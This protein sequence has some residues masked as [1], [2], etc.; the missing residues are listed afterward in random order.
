M[1]RFTKLLVLAV[2]L[3]WAV[4]EASA[5]NNRSRGQKASKSATRAG[6]SAGRR[7]TPPARGNRGVAPTRSN[8]A[9]ARARAN[10]AVARPRAER[11][12]TRTRVTRTRVQSRSRVAKPRV[13]VR[14]H[15][16]QQTRPPRARQPQPRPQPR[17]ARRNAAIDYRPYPRVAYEYSYDYEMYVDDTGEFAWIP[18]YWEWYD[19]EWVWMQGY[20]TALR[21]GYYFQPGYWSDAG[22]RYSRVAG[23][24]IQRSRVRDQRAPRIRARARGSERVHAFRGGARGARH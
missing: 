14:D 8:R 24:W 2:A 17:R 15:R 6:N 16:G 23:R 3:A 19:G 21:V 18:G 22:G 12:P 9:P 13:V 11:T 20:W 7:A 4:P 10:R 5:R 1:Q